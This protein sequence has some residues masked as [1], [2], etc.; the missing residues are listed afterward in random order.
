MNTFFKKYL[1]NSLIWLAVIIFLSFQ[2]NSCTQEKTNDINIMTYNIRYASFN[3]NQENWNNRKDGVISLLHE[4][5]F[6]GLQEATPVQIKDIKNALGN[7]YGLI[8][9]SREVDPEQGEASPVLYRKDLWELLDSGTFWL[10]ATP[11]I[12]GSNTWG[13]AYNRV[14]SYGLFKSKEG[15]DSILV[16]NTHLDHICQEARI[17]GTKLIHERLGI[18][19]DKYPSVFMGDLNV[20]DNNEV[21]AYITSEMKLKDSYRE[22]HPKFSIRD[23]TF[24]G[25]ESD[26][27]NIRIDYIF[28]NHR[29]SAKEV[30]VDMT[31]VNHS[32]PSDHFP[33]EAEL[34][35]KDN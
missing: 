13:A 9:R 19:I 6:I 25:W 3:D 1:S 16:I 23:N 27:A 14:S 5:D 33:V 34:V 35:I 31:K 29:I 7:E 26:T 18:F 32:Y 21:Y 10:S 15:R 17:K 11:D 12:P 2:L 8:S 28:I 4:H 24:H 20:E 22:V 30:R